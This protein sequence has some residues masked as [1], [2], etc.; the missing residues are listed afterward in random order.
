MSLLDK[1]KKGWRTEARRAPKLAHHASEHTS[2][3]E[4][5]LD[6]LKRDSPRFRERIE[7]PIELADGRSYE[8]SADIHDDLF[9]TAHSPGESK[10][11]ESEFVRPSHRFG[12]DVLDA[13]VKTD[14]H[15]DAK[16]YME[17]DELASAIY[18]NAAAEKF[19]ELMRDQSVQ[20]EVE[21]SQDAHEQEQRLENVE[22]RIKDIRDEAKGTPGNIPGPLVEEFSQ[23][24]DEREKICGNMPTDLPG[25]PG[26]LPGPLQTAVEA[27][28]AAGKERVDAWGTIAGSGVADLGRISPDE[29][30][31]LTEQW[32]ALPD[33]ME[34]SKLLGRIQRDFRAQDARNV[35]G[36]DDEIV[37][38]EL[39]NNLTNTLPS[40]LGRLGNPLTQR[41]FLRDYAEESLLQF[42]TQGSEKVDMGPGVLCI[43]LSGSMGSTSGAMGF[44]KHTAAKAVAV[45]FV[46]LMHT[47]KRD[48]IVICFNGAVMWEHH[49]PKRDGL[50]MAKLLNLAGLAPS[51][52]T[53]ITKAVARAEKIIA[54]LPT[55]KRADVLVVTDGQDSFDSTDQ[56]IRDRFE[57][58]GIR[59]H[60]IA[61]GHTP[62][63]D[64]WLLKFCDDAI[65]VDDLTE[66]TGDI[67]RAVS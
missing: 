16:P 19:D 30:M 44:K 10:V 11:K 67:V 12:R 8:P 25:L 17:G 31:A 55:F 40:E 3:D 50:D 61:I 46:R 7:R 14:D 64:G 27:A 2:I 49:F 52:G 15:R 59:K 56:A 18:A 28:A 23:L 41:S 22:Q 51:G 43:D 21:Q 1:L 4:W 58:A 20:D 38:I 36:G 65:S 63:P 34:M 13:F 47:K 5:V 54:T 26:G 62:T 32:M 60:G 37:G 6:D 9:L 42:E 66:V 24:T 33:F 29:A 57:K 48:A 39:G 53:D 35:I 45:G